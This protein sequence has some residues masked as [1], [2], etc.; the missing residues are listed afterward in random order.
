MITC[1]RKWKTVGFACSTMS[2]GKKNNSK[3]LTSEVYKIVTVLFQVLFQ[4]YLFILASICRK[5]TS[6]S[7]FFL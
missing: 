7:D 3:K 6:D 2:A 5:Q 1:A 4:F